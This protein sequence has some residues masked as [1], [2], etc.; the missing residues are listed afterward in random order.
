MKKPIVLT[1]LFSFFACYGFSQEK[2]GP[3][4]VVLRYL[5]C[6][7][8]LAVFVL[9]NKSRQTIFARV[10]PV[11]YWDKWKKAN[12]QY[13]TFWSEY[14]TPESDEFINISDRFDAPR[15]FTTI[16]PGRKIRYGIPLRKGAGIYKVSVPYIDNQRMKKMLDNFGN[17]TSEEI[18]RISWNIV[19]AEEKFIPCE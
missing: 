13:D 14:R 10:N 5:N 3:R 1:I 11:P 16:R 9:E 15:D 7:S 6:E 17:L 4:A 18:E 12:A 8:D 19:S 2:T